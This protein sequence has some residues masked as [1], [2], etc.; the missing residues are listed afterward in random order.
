ML[1]IAYIPC[2]SE[3][4]AEK[5]AE[6]LIK[7]KLAAC[8]NITKIKS[9][10][11]WKGKLEKVDEWLIL[12]KTIPEKFEKLKKRVEK[13]HSYEIPCIA[14]VPLVDVNEKYLAWAESQLK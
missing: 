7:E 4:E 13:V 2:G 6:I 12:A 14:A 8:C 1:V 11:K 10:Y 9:V 3:K 5:I